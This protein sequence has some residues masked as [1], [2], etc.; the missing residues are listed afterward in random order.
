MAPFYKTKKG[1]SKNL[2]KLYFLIASKGSKIVYFYQKVPLL[3]QKIIEIYRLSGKNLSIM[4]LENLSDYRDF[5]NDNLSITNTY[6]SES[7]KNQW[8]DFLL[9]KT[10]S[11]N[12]MAG[13]RKG[14][15]KK[16]HF[17]KLIFLT[18]N[19]W[20]FQ[21]SETKMLLLFST[22]HW[23]NRYSQHIKRKQT[24]KLTV[25]RLFIEQS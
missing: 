19:E 6:W 24:K 2:K 20:T 10:A 8:F 18:T 13:L 14:H 16:I 5:D 23:E 1:S 17:V 25:I 4:I 7:N 11:S 15:C 12:S 21:P 3:R 9:N 22:T